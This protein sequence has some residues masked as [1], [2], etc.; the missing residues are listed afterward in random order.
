MVQ[1]SA[2]RMPHPKDSIAAWRC[3][4]LRPPSPVRLLRKCDFAQEVVDAL[5]ISV[6]G[7]SRV[8]DDGQS[9]LARQRQLRGQRALLLVVT[10]LLPV[11]V[12]SDLADGDHLRVLRHVPQRCQRLVV[13][14]SAVVWVDPQRGIDGR[15]AIRQ[16]KHA[17]ARVQVDGRIDEQCDP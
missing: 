12:Q 16:G 1:C 13:E 10:H 4:Y 2:E 8:Q 9:Q 3:P 7:V 14:V 6:P 5:P 11:I 15:I 17:L